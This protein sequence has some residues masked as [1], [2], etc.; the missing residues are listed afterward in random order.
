MKTSL[1]VFL[2]GAILL[3]VAILGGGFELKEL[4]VPKVGWMARLI[5]A[6]MGMVFV[7]VGIGLDAPTDDLGSPSSGS[8][9]SATSSQSA[10]NFT[11]GDN[12]G[13]EIGQVSEQVAVSINGRLV[14][15][16]TVN[17]DY[18]S[19][20]L[21]V[22]VPKPGQYTYTANGRAMFSDGIERSCAGQGGVDISDGKAFK[23][24]A[25]IGGNTC[26]IGLQEE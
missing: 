11:I 15:T 4:K 7:V 20:T 8:S 14:G 1:V 16:L 17:Q 25:N 26:S 9:S 5:S 22:T 13:V 12:L 2:F 3:A 21:T 18:P 6:F 23:L 24:N 19:T 10:I